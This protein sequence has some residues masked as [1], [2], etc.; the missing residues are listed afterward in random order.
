M[1]L[2]PCK[3]Y[4]GSLCVC[5]CVCVCVHACM[6][7]W[8]CI[9]V[10]IQVHEY[11]DQRVILNIVQ[12]ISTLFVFFFCLFVFCLFVLFLGCFCFCF[13]LFLLCC[14]EIGSLT[15]Q[16]LVKSARLAG[17]GSACP[18][19]CPHPSSHPVLG[20]Q[21]NPHHTLLFKPAF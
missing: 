5:V 2:K 3:C 8:M 1:Y 17:Q 20:Y 15:D 4:P 19:L 13:G 6:C 11:G 21:G 18:C 14:F 10:Q 12:A 9:C 7:M 16:E